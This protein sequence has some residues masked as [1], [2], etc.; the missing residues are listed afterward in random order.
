MSL[1]VQL[2]DDFKE[3][4]KARQTNKKEA[5]N[6]VLAQA[7]N[8]KIELQRDPNDDEI[9]AILKKEIKNLN[10]SIEYASKA[11]QDVSDD[12]EKIK[13]LQFYLPTMLSESQLK[14]LITTT[15]QSAGVTDLKT[16]RG[17][18]TKLLME[19][20]KSVIDGQMLNT[21]MTSMM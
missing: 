9:I 2:S 8:K 11:W 18:V 1:F 20:H 4:F 10:E 15:M 5:L 13:A 3:A 17:T 7:K 21:I 6:Y 14:D 16:G 12:Q 19:S